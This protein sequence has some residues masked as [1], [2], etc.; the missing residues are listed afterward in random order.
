MLHI[1][2]YVGTS[3]IAGVGLFTAIDLAAGQLIYTCDPRT[4][5]IL[6]DAELDA[7]P[8]GV[9]DSWRRYLYR[10]RG[11]DRLADGWYYCS[12]DAR[13]FNHAAP[14]NCRWVEARECYV[15][16]RDLP[17]HSELT[18]DYFEFCEPADVPYLQAP[19]AA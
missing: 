9:Q 10:G 13:F 7:L 12:D 2:H 19:A 3:A 18:C 14:A 17:A 4:L 1:P 16:A 15:A 8:A 5:H 11:K 6:R